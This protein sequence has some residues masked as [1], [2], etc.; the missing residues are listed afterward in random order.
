MVASFSSLLLN[1]SPLVNV[2]SDVTSDVFTGNAN[3]LPLQCKNKK[4]EDRYNAKS[5]SARIVTKQSQNMVES[6]QSHLRVF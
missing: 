4:G 3:G 6:L 1:V 2:T 5:I